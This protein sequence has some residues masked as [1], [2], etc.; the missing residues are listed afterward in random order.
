MIWCLFLKIWELWET[1]WELVTFR[2][3]LYHL[4]PRSQVKY[5]VQWCNC[6][7]YALSICVLKCAKSYGISG[8]FK[9]PLF[10]KPSKFW[11]IFACLLSNFHGNEVKFFIFFSKMF[12]EWPT[13]SF[14]TT[15]E[16]WAIPAKI[17]WIGP[18]VP[19]I[20]WCKGHWCGLTYIFERQ[21]EVSSKTDKNAF[22]M[23]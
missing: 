13:M 15:T 17:S 1:F 2:P 20:H 10:L 8:L 6:S 9:K 21:S 16:S 18:W 11:P 5:I 7:Q 22:F 12:S 3:T 19:R 14:S 23:F 4:L